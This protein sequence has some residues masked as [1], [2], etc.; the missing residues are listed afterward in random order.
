MTFSALIDGT[1]PHHNKFSSREGR[2]PTRGLNHHWA[3]IGGGDARLV[4]P[5]EAVSAN[6]ILYS[7]GR[8]FGQVP[9]EYRAWTSGSW[10]A[11]SWSITIEIQNVAGRYPGANDDDPRSWPIS[12]AAI[13]KLI[14]LWADVGARYGWGT[15]NRDRIRGHREFA[16]TAC[17][18]GY[19]WHRLGWIAAEADSLM[20]GG[21]RVPLPKPKPKRRRMDMLGMRL[22]DGEGR[23]GKAGGWL[24]ATFAPENKAVTYLANDDGKEDANQVS[25]NMGFSF[26]N[27]TYPAY[28]G[29]CAQAETF[30]DATVDPPVRLSGPKGKPG[31]KVLG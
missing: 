23:Y 10:E 27:L 17:P 3:G 19:V 26:A 31:T 22:N 29:Y 16:Q 8:L 4:N 7:D 18:G 15:I 30:I 6:Y 2:T 11:D 24:F 9:E 25:I 5:N 20:K 21:G 28:E 1:L 12:D 14:Q 13:A